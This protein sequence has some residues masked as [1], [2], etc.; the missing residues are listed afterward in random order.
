MVGF[1]HVY[2]FCVWPFWSGTQCTS[3]SDCGQHLCNT[4]GPNSF[5]HVNAYKNAHTHADKNDHAYAD[6]NAHAYSRLDKQW[7]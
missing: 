7:P 6:K 4:N 1:G 5:P 3:N 2:H